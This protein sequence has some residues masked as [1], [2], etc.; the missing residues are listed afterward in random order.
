M[1]TLLQWF[2]GKK[3]KVFILTP[4]II[5]VCQLMANDGSYSSIVQRPGSQKEKYGT[6]RYILLL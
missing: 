1:L 6:L 5:S 3:K 2:M 4:V